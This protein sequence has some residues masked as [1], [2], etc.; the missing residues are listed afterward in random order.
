MGL[1]LIDKIVTDM[2]GYLFDPDYGGD[3]RIL[4]MFMDRE[5]GKPEQPLAHSGYIGSLTLKSEEELNEQ[6]ERYRKAIGQT[7][8]IPGP[9]P[10]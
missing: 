2:F 5:D 4:N 1:C 8:A 9:D 7:A 6:L 10:S 3:P